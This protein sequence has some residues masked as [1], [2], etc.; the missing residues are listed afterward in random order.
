[1]TDTINSTLS[2]FDI[3]YTVLIRMQDTKKL[4]NSEGLTADTKASKEIRALIVDLVGTIMT[5]PKSTFVKS[6]PRQRESFALFE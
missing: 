1:V 3:L 2:S 4:C 6:S 5:F